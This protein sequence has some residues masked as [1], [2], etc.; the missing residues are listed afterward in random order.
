M[1]NSAL[2]L[3]VIFTIIKVLVPF[4]LFGLGPVPPLEILEPVVFYVQ[5]FVMVNSQPLHSLKKKKKKPHVCLQ[6]CLENCVLLF[7]VMLFIS[8][9]TSRELGA[10]GS[11]Y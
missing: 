2:K 9:A 11:P 6:V 3:L 10:M 8:I 5:G 7:F 1:P 4:A